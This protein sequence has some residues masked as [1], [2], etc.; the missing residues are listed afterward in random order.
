MASYCILDTPQN[1]FADY[2]CFKLWGGDFFSDHDV[3]LVSSMKMCPWRHS[4]YDLIAHRIS[5]KLVPKLPAQRQGGK[6]YGD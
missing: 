2:D 5:N 6:G 3:V 4:T 1:A